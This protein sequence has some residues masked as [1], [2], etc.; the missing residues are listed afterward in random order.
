MSRSHVWHTNLLSGTGTFGQKTWSFKEVLSALR[1]I[2]HVRASPKLEAL[3]ACTL[4][5]LPGS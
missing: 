2:R 3:A 4:K 1:S 5:N